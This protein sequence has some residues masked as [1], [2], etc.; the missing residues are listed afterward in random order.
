[1]PAKTEREPDEFVPGADAQQIAELERKLLE[2][3]QRWNRDTFQLVAARDAAESAIAE[4][5]LNTS[6]C[7]L[8]AALLPACQPNSP[9]VGLG[10]LLP[11]TK[12]YLPPLCVD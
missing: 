2:E 11:C 7:L 9:S 5:E 12:A 10:L 1:M 6:M 4:R 8:K 3:W